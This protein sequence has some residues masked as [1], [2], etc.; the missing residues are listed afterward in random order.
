MIQQDVEGSK[1]RAT[2]NQDNAQDT[3]VTFIKYWTSVLYPVQKMTSHGAYFEAV[4]PVKSSGSKSAKSILIWSLFC[5]LTRVEKVWQLL[6]KVD[7][8]TSDWHGWVLVYLA[9]N[10]FN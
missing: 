3:I 9:K 8:R 6:E 7:M 4:P 5:M 2:L 10:Y 1:I